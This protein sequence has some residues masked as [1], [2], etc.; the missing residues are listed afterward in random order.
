MLLITQSSI[1]QPRPPA[2]VKLRPFQTLARLCPAVCGSGRGVDKSFE[3]RRRPP[4]CARTTPLRR[5]GQTL[6]PAELAAESAARVA[7][8]LEAKPGTRSMW[9]RRAGARAANYHAADRPQRRKRSRWQCA[10]LAAEQTALGSGNFQGKAAARLAMAWR[11][12]RA[13]VARASDGGSQRRCRQ[14]LEPCLE[15]DARRCHAWRLGI[16]LQA[17]HQKN[18]CITHAFTHVRYTSCAAVKAKQRE[19]AA[20]AQKVQRSRLGQCSLRV[21]GSQCRAEH[22]TVQQR[23]QHASAVNV[24]RPSQPF[25]SKT[26]DSACCRRVQRLQAQLPRRH[27]CVYQPRLANAW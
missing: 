5:Q 18:L 24:K 21:Y 3:K 25:H 10:P 26:N 14:L 27:A 19:L 9:R 15:L 17:I 2:D 13:P 7:A 6:G 8:A 1:A 16:K 4:N 11:E 23:R 12:A 20:A 22:E